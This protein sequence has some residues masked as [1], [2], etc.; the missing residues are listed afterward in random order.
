[1]CALRE[2]FNQTYSPKESVQVGED[3]VNKVFMAQFAFMP[4]T[5][6]HQPG[7][8]LS[9]SPDSHEGSRM[10]WVGL[11]DTPEGIQVTAAD[12]PEVDGKFVDYDLALL[13]RTQPHT[14]RFWIEVNPGPDNDLV[15]IAVDDRDTGQCFTTWENYYRT[16]PEQAPPPNA[17]TPA[18]I[19]SLQFRSSV[20][21]PPALLTSGGYLF[22]NV[23]ITPSNGRWTPGCRLVIDKEADSRTVRAGGLVGYRITAR[24]RG[25][26][27]DRNVQLCD[28]IPRGTRFVS[29]NRKLR[30]I[31]RR[32]CLVIPR[33]RAGERA[34]F[35]LTLRVDA[36]AEPGTLENIA[37]ITPGVEPPG[38]GTSPTTESPNLPAAPGGRPQ[39]RH[40]LGAHVRG[41]TARA[42]VRV[43]GR[44]QPRFTG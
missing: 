18:D 3:R 31:G 27:S 36:N 37:D 25:R 8:F 41:R 44:V 23:S 39:G 2:F 35:H 14:I 32:R 13:D 4:R 1:M 6:A 21:G 38:S 10:S 30:R 9:V 42:R 34:G 11:E 26:G 19:N 29:A 12:A 24:N 40:V 16:A 43:L 28:R 33:L 20:Q 15:R 7:L 5:S 22:D 17:N